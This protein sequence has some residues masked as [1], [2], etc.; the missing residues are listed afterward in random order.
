VDNMV[1]FE[2]RILGFSKLV[3]R[4][5]IESLRKRKLDCEANIIGVK[6]R[7]KRGNKYWKVDVGNSG[8]YMVEYLTGEI[9]GIRGYGQ[10]NRKQHYGNL[11][12]I[13]DWYWG[14]HRAFK[15]P[16]RC[17]GKDKHN[18]L[19]KFKEQSRT[20][21]EDEKGKINLLIL[22]C[23]HCG[24]KREMTTRPMKVDVKQL[25]EIFTQIFG[26]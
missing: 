19:H 20:I 10:I 1:D 7:I 26:E 11:K 12:T 9:Y 16:P 22:G 4:Q 21:A 25:H 5:Q 2:N 3:E 24:L 15:K 14:E 8:K 13:H 6:T 17:E 18:G 23:E